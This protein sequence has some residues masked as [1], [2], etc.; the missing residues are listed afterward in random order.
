MTSSGWYKESQ[1]HAMASKGIKS[2]IKVSKI[3]NK[4]GK[5]SWNN[6]VVE[7]MFNMG[8]VPGDWKW[9]GEYKPT[10]NDGEPYGICEICDHPGCADLYK[11]KTKNDD[12]LW[13]GSECV[14]TMGGASVSEYQKSQINE[15]KKQSAIVGRLQ[16]VGI[17]EKE[18]SDFKRKFNYSESD[19]MINLVS[20]SGYPNR[21]KLT[22]ES[23]NIVKQSNYG[24]K[25]E[26]LKDDELVVYETYVSNN[27]NW[28][29]GKGQF[30]TLYSGENLSVKDIKSIPHN[31]KL[32][33]VARKENWNGRDVWVALRIEEKDTS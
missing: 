10:R 15:I 21:V 20:Y 7:R 3:S 12:T 33:I 9:T 28:V 13:V 23:Y 19:N 29:S 8:T 24:T 11:M 18:I 2:T 1:R 17:E 22:K 31:K 27:K 6:R 14:E 16:R 32:K 5:S 4:S 25:K 26:V 30:I